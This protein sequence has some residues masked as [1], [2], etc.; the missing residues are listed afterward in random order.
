[1]VAGRFREL[2]RE[3]PVLQALSGL[4]LLCVV[5]AVAPGEFLS[6]QNITNVLRQIS[7]NAII[8]IGMTMV[9]LCGGIDLSVGAVLALSMT[10]AAGA[11][12]AG[13]SCTLAVLMA[14][15]VGDC[16]WRHQRGLHRLFSAAGHYCY[17][18]HDGDAPGCSAIVYERLSTLRLASTCSQR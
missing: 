13:I 14:L 9:I 3:S 4:L 15:G 8:A 11:M 1:M 2:L 16:L 6:L 18:G 17:T 10:T 12:L 7:I 5:M